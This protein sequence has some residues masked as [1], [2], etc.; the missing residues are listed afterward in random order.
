VGA[1]V[2]LVIATAKAHDIDG[3]CEHKITTQFEHCQKKFVRKNSRF[4]VSD[5]KS[6]TFAFSSSP[7]RLLYLTPHLHL[8]QHCGRFLSQRI[9]ETRA[10]TAHWTQ[11]DYTLSICG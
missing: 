2:L 3:L 8:M 11:N 4:S 1:S 10:D 6:L 7:A 9:S 5:E